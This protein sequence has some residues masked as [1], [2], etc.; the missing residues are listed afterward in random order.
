MIKEKSFNQSIF[1]NVSIFDFLYFLLK[2]LVSWSMWLWS[3]WF[4]HFCSLWEGYWGFEKI[5][6]S[7]LSEILIYL[8]LACEFTPTWYEP[9]C[10]RP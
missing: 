8:W 6:G 1:I 9:K 10:G 4:S 7:F 3:D 5:K 2:E